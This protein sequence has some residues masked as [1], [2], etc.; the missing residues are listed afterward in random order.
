MSQQCVRV[1]RFPKRA[2]SGCMLWQS[3]SGMRRHA[4]SGGPSHRDWG[5]RGDGLYRA[6]GGKLVCFERRTNLASEWHQ[7]MFTKAR[8]IDVTNQDHFVMV[9]LKDCIIDHVYVGRNL[10]FSLWGWEWREH[11]KKKK[12]GAGVHVGVA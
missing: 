5:G 7:M 1:L 8:N 11:E 10:P 9:L 4:V 6:K 2:C 12:G 3:A